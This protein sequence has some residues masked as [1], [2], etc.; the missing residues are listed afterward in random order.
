MQLE[1]LLSLNPGALPPSQTLPINSEGKVLLQLK[2]HLWVLPTHY[3]LWTII[4]PCSMACATYSRPRPPPP[5]LYHL[6]I[7]R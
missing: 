3:A 6:Y 2:H 4:Q 1:L 5:P 7:P